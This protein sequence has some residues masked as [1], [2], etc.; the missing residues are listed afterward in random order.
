MNWIDAY[1]NVIIERL[2]FKDI[3]VDVK[4]LS[5]PTI[6][7]ENHG[8]R[9]EILLKAGL[10]GDHTAKLLYSMLCEDYLKLFKEEFK[11]SKAFTDEHQQIL[12]NL[13]RLQSKH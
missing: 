8:K 4:A 7:R 5:G 11:S 6:L 2:K 1:L 3:S 9:L 10:D 12:D 13:N